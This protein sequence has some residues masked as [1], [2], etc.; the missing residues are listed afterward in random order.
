MRVGNCQIDLICPVYWICPRHCLEVGEPLVL[1]VFLQSR[2]IDLGDLVAWEA[3]RTQGLEELD[4]DVL[5]Q[6]HLVGQGVGVDLVVQFPCDLVAFDLEVG[7]DLDLEVVD[8]EAALDWDRQGVDL[9][10]PCHIHHELVV[11]DVEIVDIDWDCHDLD[12][13]DLNAVLDSFHRDLYLDIHVVG[14]G[15]DEVVLVLVV[16]GVDELDC[17]LLVVVAK[18][19]EVVQDVDGLVVGG[20]T[21]EVVVVEGEV[22]VALEDEAI[23]HCK[24]DH[25]SASI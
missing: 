16:E 17:S 19:H 14:Q 10:V 13:H 9:T 7:I 12:C 2:M 8:L 21:A 6:E 15:V 4:V 3:S 22:D 20:E 25:H 5:V 23:V 18:G 1:L 24:I 11:H